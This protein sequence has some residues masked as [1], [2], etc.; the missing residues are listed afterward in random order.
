[1]YIYITLKTANKLTAQ[2]GSALIGVLVAVV[3]IGIVM[4]AMVKS[5]GSQS[6]STRSFG[7]VLT[8]NSTLNS[9]MIATEMYFGS[10]SKW[11][12]VKNKLN[13]IMANPA[14]PHYVYGDANTRETISKGQEFRSQLTKFCPNTR[15][16]TF[17]VASSNGGGRDIRTAKAFYWMDVELN[18]LTGGAWGTNAFYMGKG[19]LTSNP[20]F[21]V[22]GYATFAA[23]L[24]VNEPLTFNSEADA[25]FAADNL[26]RG[27]VYFRSPVTFNSSNINFTTNVYFHNHVNMN[28]VNTKG[29]LQPVFGKSVGFKENFEAGNRDNNG[30]ITVAG[31]VWIDGKF[32]NI[33]GDFT[34][35]KISST[36]DTGSFNYNESNIPVL[37]S[38]CTFPIND[39]CTIH[40][41]IYKN[42]HSNLSLNT[43]GP[44]DFNN[45]VIPVSS[46][47]T[48]KFILDSLKML[49]FQKRQE[50][51]LILADSGKTFYKFSNNITMTGNS[52]QDSISKW[53]QNSA[54]EKYFH[55]DRNGHLLLDA[56][57]VEWNGGTFNDKVVIKAT[58]AMNVNG[59]F[60]K[61]EN[62][63]S[64]MI[65]VDKNG[66]LNNMGIKDGGIFRGLIYVHH[67]NQQDIS[68]SPGSNND[69]FEGAVLFNGG[70][71]VYWNINSTGIT[72][73]RRNDEAISAF[74]GMLKNLDTGKLVGGG[75]PNA[76]PTVKDP[77]T[78][79]PI[80]VEKVGVYFY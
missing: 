79:G 21:R 50:P 56:T 48:E 66:T 42:Q 36:T 80:A 22:E 26:G 75:D 65:Y 59:N 6:A 33:N 32:A 3:F 60:Y 57:G 13:K 40:Y 45:K 2:S 41:G 25:Q 64:T 14:V 30:S 5:T 11:G 67:E 18:P 73:I 43:Q 10:E 15:V 37:S 78:P 1:P 49:E 24:S 47:M 27:D 39:I 53:R 7:T 72:T 68:F 51:N 61:S 74:G 38:T 35:T 12:D 4:G 77:S 16:G 9:G 71:K 34:G 31:N 19:R 55:P 63:A 54:Y 23:P 69:T 17:D 46:P 76:K 28:T 8:A 62:K 29:M 52:L 44:V 70:N 58:G 20:K